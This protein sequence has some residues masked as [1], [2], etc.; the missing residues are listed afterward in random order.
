MILDEIVA[1]KRIELA[2]TRRSIPLDRLEALGAQR[3]APL[4]LGEALRKTGV[5]LIAEV[6]RA[7]PS[8]GEF[9][10]ELEPEELAEI[11]AVNGAAAISVLTDQQFFRGQLEFIPRIKARLAGATDASHRLPLLRKDFVF[12]PY[13]VIESYAYGADALLLVVAILSD[14]VLRELLQLSRDLGMSALVE[15]HDERE[16]ER[17]LENKAEIVGINNRDLRDFSVDLET[18]GRLATNLPATVVAVAESGVYSAADVRRLKAMGADAVLV[19][20]ALVTATDVGMKVQ[21][22]AYAGGKH[23]QRKQTR[24]ATE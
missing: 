24:G 22:L 4:N 6:K 10:L 12:D 3:Q 15:V 18:F 2:Q 17:A 14:N 13:Q 1:H 20:E 16:L 7:S 23:V 8:R 11:Y 21:E 5:G 19:G 9:A